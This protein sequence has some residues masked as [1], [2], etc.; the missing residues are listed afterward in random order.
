MSRFREFRLPNHCPLLLGLN[1]VGNNA[2]IDRAKTVGDRK[3]E[4]GI[5]AV[6]I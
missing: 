6:P 2:P 3:Q 1:F 5:A 4:N